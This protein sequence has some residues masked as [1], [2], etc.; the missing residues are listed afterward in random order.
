MKLAMIFCHALREHVYQEGEKLGL[1][2]EVLK[3]FSFTGY[4][5]EIKYNVDEKT[6]ISYPVMIDGRKILDKGEVR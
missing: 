4:Q 2:G 6:G 1:K 3:M 5:H